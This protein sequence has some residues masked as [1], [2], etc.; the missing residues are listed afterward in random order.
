[1]HPPQPP[2]PAEPTVFLVGAGPGNPGLLTVR[3]AEVLARADLVL[4]DQLVPARLLEVAPA[5]AERVCVRDL[6]GHGCL[7]LD[8]NLPDMNGLALLQI[9]RQ[10]GTTMPAILITTHPS[11]ALCARA[12][13]MGIRIV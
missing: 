9:L 7:V 13:A 5:T 2:D 12:S 10:R 1:M 8:Y 6:P 4:Y 11:R 3:A